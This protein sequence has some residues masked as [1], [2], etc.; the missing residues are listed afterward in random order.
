MVAVLCEDFGLRSRN[1]R[2][3][4]LLRADRWLYN[5][6]ATDGKTLSQLIGEAIYPSGR[7]I[8]SDY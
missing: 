2:G 6:P 5:Q 3:E 1:Q 4:T 7:F 8:L